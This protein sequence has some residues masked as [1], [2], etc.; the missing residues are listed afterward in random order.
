MAKSTQSR[1]WLITQSAEK[2]T[3]EELEEAL[4][5]YVYVGQLEK[6]TEGGEENGY[7][8]YQ[9]YIEN[10]VA[11]RFDTLKKK[12]PNAHIEQRKG[13][14]K[15]AFAYVTKTETRFG[16]VFG[17]GEID[18]TEEQGKRNDIAEILQMIEDGASDNEIR[19]AY[20]SQFV[21]YSNS[22][23]RARQVI[24]ESQ[25]ENTFRTLTV[26]YI[27]GSTGKGKT[28][29]V[30]E[31]FGYTQVYRATNYAHPF[32]M[33]KGQKVIIFEEFRSSLKIEQMLNYLDG[34]PLTLP[35]RYG[36][37]IACFDTV[38]II[39][40]IPLNGQYTNIQTEQP[41]TFNAF[42]RRIGYVWDCDRQIQPQPRI[43][44]QP[45]QQ[46]FTNLKPIEDDSN[47]PF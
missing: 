38:Y 5:D 30:M 33:Y 19:K 10:P 28:R 41:E 15:Q 22:I 36:D 39:S 44:Q 35:A 27:Y 2:I 4:A 9:L 29:Y 16:E 40:N 6:G 47:L 13:T 42:L 11:I 25:F 17:N 24:V 45:K 7:L 23:A 34:Y 12:L 3:L 18:I 32:D 46:A 8:H 26:T 20:P 31:K 1:S 21:R 14:R 37:K 43:P